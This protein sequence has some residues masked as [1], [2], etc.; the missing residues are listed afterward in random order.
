[1]LGEAAG[2]RLQAGPGGAALADG[3]FHLEGVLPGEVEPIHAPE[4]ANVA[5]RRV[6]DARGD[7]PEQVE[8]DIGEEWARH[9]EPAQAVSAV[10]GAAGAVRAATGPWMTP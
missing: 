6:Y 7:V 9:T 2:R 8:E 3:G 5:A 4:M 10:Q 1:V